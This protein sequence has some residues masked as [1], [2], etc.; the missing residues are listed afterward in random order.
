MCMIFSKEQEERKVKGRG[1][2]EEG[3][4]KERKMKSV[5]RGG[6]EGAK[7]LRRG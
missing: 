4:G 5:R 6:T 7:I 1:G 2:G 3:A